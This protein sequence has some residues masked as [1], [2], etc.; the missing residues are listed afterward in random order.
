M[1][2]VYSSMYIERSFYFL[3]PTVPYNTSN[4]T[5]HHEPIPSVNPA[6]PLFYRDPESQPEQKK[7]EH[8]NPVN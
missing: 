2:A 5:N 1:H 3:L 8:F 6:N 7:W 4:D